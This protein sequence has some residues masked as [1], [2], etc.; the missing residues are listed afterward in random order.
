MKKIILVA[1]LITSSAVFSQEIRLLK[2]AITENLVVNDSLQETYSIYLPTSFELSKSWP[3]VFVFDM[4]GN[5]KASISMLL[6]AAENEGYILASSNNLNDTL[7]IT[8]NVLVANRMFNAVINTIPIA[9]KRTYTAGFGNGARFASILPTFVKEIE[10]VISIG[11]SV[12]NVDILNI[13]QSFQFIGIV[14]R[15]DYNFTEMLQV[16]KILDKLKFPNQ[17]FVFDGEQG[18]PDVKTISTAM[19]ILTLSGMAKGNVVRDDTLIANTYDQLMIE[20]NSF[21]S[22]KKPILAT[23]LLS[24][25][26]R[27]FS[28]FIDLDSLKTSQKYL[29]RSSSYKQANRIQNS[30]FLKESFAKED[31]SYYLEEDILTYNFANLGW[32]NYQMKELDK[33][34][35]S[36][37]LFERQTASRLRG[38]INALIAD[39]VDFIAAAEELDLEA[40]NLLYMIKTITTPNEYFSYLKIIS[41]SAK[42][43]DYGTALFYLEELLKNGYDNKKELYTLEHTALLRI[44]PE[45]N[46]LVEKY[47][48]EARYDIIEQ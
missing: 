5:A 2:G 30:Y 25:I 24:D 40:L 35:K 13:K 12:G 41:N 27:V 46:E 1:L 33:L 17:L 37:V 45:F 47:L 19:R 38:Y 3:V 11:A 36:A 9:K 34:D 23:Y 26:E 4:N 39:N 16:R 29:R 48:K 10:G 44:T 32:W 15:S 31:Y 43:E 18:L 14:N 6:N 20:A 7:S 28:P 21:L 22:N 8:Q 42:M